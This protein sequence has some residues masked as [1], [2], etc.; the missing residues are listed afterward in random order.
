MGWIVPFSGG[1]DSTATIIVMLENKITIDKIVHVRMMATESIYATHQIMVDFVDDCMARFISLGLNVEIIRSIPFDSFAKKIF[2]KSK[3]ED[4]IGKNYGFTSCMRRMCS[5]QKEKVRCCA[6]ERSNTMLGICYDEPERMRPGI[7]S[8]L[9]EKKITQSMS[10]DIC[11]RHGML[12]PLYGI[13]IKR[14][15][16]FFCPNASKKERKLLNN[17]QLKLIDTWARM[18]PKSACLQED[19]RFRLEEINIQQELF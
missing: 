7:H 1:K 13:G 10:F 18:T 9:F 16:C 14:D 12:S 8:I 17:E 6:T 3:Y 4:R 19:W 2:K 5:F 15:G 11:K